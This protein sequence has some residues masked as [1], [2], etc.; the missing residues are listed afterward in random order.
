MA[1]RKTQ[2]A[3]PR[4][5]ANSVRPKISQTEVPA[6]PLDEALR[7]PKAIADHYGYKPTKPLNVA[8]G[9][10]VQPNSS[11]F[12]MLAGA[13]IAYG[14]TAG[15][16]NAPEISITPLGMRIVR[17]TVEG[18]DL[19]AKR[20][21]LLKPRV[22]GEFL[23]KYADAPVPRE[24]IAVNVLQEMGVPLER[25]SAV[26]QLIL[27]GAAAVGFFRDI[28][29][30]RYVTL[31]GVQPS[32]AGESES[33]EEEPEDELSDEGRSPAAGVTSSAVPSLAPSLL[34]GQV[35][36]A[37]RR[38]YITHGKNRSFIEP[39]KK[40]LSFGELEPV[41]SVEKPSV[42]Q[43][44]PEKIMGEMR[45]C[46]AAIIHVDAEL[47]L[48]DADANEHIVLNPNVLMEIGA[49]M[50]LFGRR[51]ILLVRDGIKLPSNLQ[52]LFEVRYSGETLDGDATVRLLEAIR[53]IKNHPM[54]ER[55]TS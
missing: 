3:A 45:S 1:A 11:Q 37:L 6:Y 47:K 21:A 32:A 13:A 14:L 20:E 9:M 39:V 52:G 23:R 33:A 41:V 53:D 10:G 31:E 42:S 38:V 27:E 34:G 43:P 4:P 28:K 7:I 5:K 29:G 46:G 18:D 26:L 40:L 49:A 8:A 15:G 2:A 17:C 22:V 19:R 54:P 16:P 30:K 55:Y 48:L 36:N 24:D 25:T 44:V 50:A 51:F 35:A 12:R